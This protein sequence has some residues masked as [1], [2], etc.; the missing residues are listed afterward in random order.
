[1][2]LIAHTSIEYLKCRKANPG[3]IRITRRV[4]T[5]FAVFCATLA[6]GC[7]SNNCTDSICG[8]RNS[9][10]EI[11]ETES[12]KSVN[13]GYLADLIRKGPFSEPLP[14]GLKVRKFIDVQMSDNSPR[15]DA[16][17]AVFELPDVPSGQELGFGGLNL[18]IETYRE[19]REATTNAQN[20]FKALGS[21]YRDFGGTEGTYNNFSL[22]TNA[23]II[24][25]GVR[26]HVYVEAWV[27]P[28]SNANIP[29][30]TG[31]KNAALRYAD[32]MTTLASGSR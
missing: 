5:S 4:I 2:A 22:N 3:A 24:A 20:R 17:R 30:A 8:D 11:R 32:R 14:V 1:M 18:Y 12:R 19:R 6:A 15:I 27:Y 23:E 10:N 28:V 25:A 31:V 13:S 9:G 7:T 16:V 21:Q 29:I 26:E